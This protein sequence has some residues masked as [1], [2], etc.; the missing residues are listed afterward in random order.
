MEKLNIGSRVKVND[1]YCG[2]KGTVE[3]IVGS[4]VIVRIGKYTESFHESDL[5]EI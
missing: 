3:E 2:K 4:F 5:T 1:Y